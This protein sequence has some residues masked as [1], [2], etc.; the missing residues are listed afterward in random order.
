MR[1]YWIVPVVALIAAGQQT[2][3][4]KPTSAAPGAPAKFTLNLN[5]VIV[6]VTVKDK[7]GNAVD[8]LTKDDFIVLEDGKPQ[9]VNIFEHQKLTMDPEAPEPPPS[10]ED[11]NEL[12][13]ASQDDHHLG[14]RHQDSVSRQAPAWRCSSISPTCRCRINSARRMPP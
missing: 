2:P 4:Q 8:S 6:D 1:N 11:K 10:L 9:S 12:P 13:A 14:G 5:T 7:A 3:P